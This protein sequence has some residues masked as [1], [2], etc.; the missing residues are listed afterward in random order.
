ML[1]NSVSNAALLNCNVTVFYYKQKSYSF[2]FLGRR[3]S[4]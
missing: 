1:P 2:L 4:K 3:H